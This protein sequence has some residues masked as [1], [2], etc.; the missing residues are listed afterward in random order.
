MNLFYNASTTLLQI[1]KYL[2]N[3][4]LPPVREYAHT[5]MHKCFL[6]CVFSISE[7]LYSIREVQFIA[8][9]ALVQGLHHLDVVQARCLPHNL[10][11]N[12]F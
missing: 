3:V 8:H 4:R 5:A 1:F 12:A 9:A 11:I 2:C 7:T 10:K 6:L